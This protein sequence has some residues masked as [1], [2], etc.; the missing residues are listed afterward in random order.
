MWR[1]NIRTDMRTKT[2]SPSPKDHSE[3]QDSSRTNDKQ[4]ALE[5]H[6]A[7][8]RSNW[9]TPLDRRTPCPWRDL[10]RADH[11]T[12]QLKASH[13]DNQLQEDRK[14]QAAKQTNKWRC[15]KATQTRKTKQPVKRTRAPA[16]ERNGDELEAMPSRK[17]QHPASIRHDAPATPRP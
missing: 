6:G 7:R 15:T 11:H 9:S 8:R 14:A 16:R 13:Q 4:L 5:F 2:R 10:A 17:I 1:A 12:L 3:V